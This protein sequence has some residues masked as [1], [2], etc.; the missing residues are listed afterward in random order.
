MVCR[1]VP[2]SFLTPWPRSCRFYRE[3]LVMELVAGETLRARLRRDYRIDVPASL[4]IARQTAEALAALHRVGFIHGDIK[5]ENIRLVGD[6][7]AILIDLGFAHR[8]GENAPFL[9][10]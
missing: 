7:T 8:Q 6:G 1:R 4:W 3:F 10:K 9:E 5:P 2:I